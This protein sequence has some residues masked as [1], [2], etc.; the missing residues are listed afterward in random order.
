MMSISVG[1]ISPSKHSFAD[2]REITEMAAEMRRQDTP[3]S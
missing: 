3:S 2:I 1:I